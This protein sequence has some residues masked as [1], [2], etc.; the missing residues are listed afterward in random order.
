M[1]RK[2]F[3]PEELVIETDAAPL[4]AILALPSECRSLV[5]FAHGAG[6]SRHSPRN[7]YVAGKLNE[8]GFGTVLM[9][10]LTADEERIDANTGKL[11]FDIPLLAGRLDSATEWVLSDRRTA[12]LDIGY[13]GASTGAAAAL[14]AAVQRPQIVKAVV[15]RGGRPDLAVR[16]LPEVEAP[17]LLL[18]GGKDRIV[19]DMNTEA[20]KSLHTTCELIVVP[21]ASH[22]FEEPGTLAAVANHA[23]AWFRRY[24]AVAPTHAAHVERR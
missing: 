19:L 2:G 21:G 13:F 15:S 3:S 6:S 10:L 9:D 24:M 14:V 1:V 5:L 22:L 12:G 16:I 11:R 18:V 7:R 4:E 20:A 23:T 8:V 17:V